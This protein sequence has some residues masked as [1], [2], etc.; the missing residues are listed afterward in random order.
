MGF[1]QQRLSEVSHDEHDI[2]PHNDAADVVCHPDRDV[3]CHTPEI[4]DREVD[5]NVEMPHNGLLLVVLSI[6]PLGKPFIKFSMR[7]RPRIA[8][9]DR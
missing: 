4:Y 7:I 6:A 9:Y 3:Q 8:V 2:Q 1:F 5:N